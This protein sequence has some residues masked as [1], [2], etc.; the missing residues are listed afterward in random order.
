[1]SDALESLARRVAKDPFFLAAP[2]ARYAERHGLD[3]AALAGRLGCPQE[4]LIDLRLC[5]NPHPEPPGFWQ[6][7]ERIATHFHLDADRLAE[8]VR[9]GQALLYLFQVQ[10]NA[11]A[12]GAGRAGGAEAEAP[13]FLMAARDE[14]PPHPPRR[15]EEEPEPEPEP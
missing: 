3:D 14:E 12:G 7:V 1:M 8:V 4:L 9:D 11:D 2:L 15:P 10:P 5:R 6:D 13:G